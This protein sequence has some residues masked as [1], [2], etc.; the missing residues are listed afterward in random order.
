MAGADPKVL[1]I[2][3]RVCSC[4]SLLGSIFI[5]STF[6]CSKAFHKPINRLVFYASIGNF[7]VNI[8]TLIATTYIDR[9]ASAG[10]Q[11]QAFMIEWLLGADPLWTLAMATNVYLRIYHKYDTTALKKFEIIYIL[12]CYGIPFIPSFIFLFVTGHNGVKMYGNAIL[13]C[14]LSQKW[15]LLRILIIYGPVW[16]F[17]L[18]TFFIYGR[19]GCDLIHNHRQVR[20]LSRTDIETSTSTSTR[21]DT[22]AIRA[23]DSRTNGPPKLPTKPIPQEHRGSGSGSGTSQASCP[24]NSVSAAANDS[25]NRNR[26]TTPALSRAELQYAKCA[27]LFF[28]AMLVTWLPST[29]NRVY[30]LIHPDSEAPALE[31][32]SAAVLPLQGFWNAMIYMV[33]SWAA[34]RVVF[35]QIM[36]IGRSADMLSRGKAGDDPFPNIKRLGVW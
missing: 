8:F 29:A 1:S 27:L 19:I 12:I 15:R 34:C 32:M 14:W 36:H 13:W 7:T 4:F 20:N 6:C 35:G 11:I 31:Y 5:I 24:D 30:L 18:I 3:E 21:V 25:N 26:T 16:I 22:G 10:C 17:I 33:T 9:P 28:T 23:S 2:I